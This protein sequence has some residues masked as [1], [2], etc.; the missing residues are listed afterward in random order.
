MPTFKTETLHFS[1]LQLI[2]W[3]LLQNKWQLQHYLVLPQQY[4]IMTKAT[5]IGYINSK[6]QTNRKAVGL[7]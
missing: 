1:V 6:F 7:V 2:I 4:D 5:P 3:H